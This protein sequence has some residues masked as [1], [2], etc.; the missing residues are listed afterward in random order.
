LQQRGDAPVSHRPGEPDLLRWGS[1]LH[2]ALQKIPLGAVSRNG[3]AE[4][5]TGREELIPNAGE[6]ANP[7]R[8]LHQTSKID[9]PQGV[10][11]LKVA[12]RSNI[13]HAYATGKIMDS[14]ALKLRKGSEFIGNMFGDPDHVVKPWGKWRHG[15][16]ELP[17]GGMANGDPPDSGGQAAQDF[18]GGSVKVRHHC[19]GLEARDF[20]ENRRDN[21]LENQPT[22]IM[23]HHFDAE[24]L[25]IF[26]VPVIG[27]EIQH[28]TGDSLAD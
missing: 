4:G 21:I 7:L 15:L 1:G 22:R 11:G 6:K 2:L 23:Q 14:R 8:F 24:V 28:K 10:A 18:I 13:W 5:N 19:G 12:H 17:I 9:D 20:I 26:S 25:E 27:F 3:P 16:I